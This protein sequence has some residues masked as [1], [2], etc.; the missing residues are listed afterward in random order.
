MDP[1]FRL[2]RIDMKPEMCSLSNPYSDFS[3]CG[4]AQWLLEWSYGGALTY[5][6][7]LCDA[8][9]IEL[10]RLLLTEGHP[11]QQIPAWLT[12]RNGG[13]RCTCGRGDSNPV[14]H[15]DCIIT[16]TREG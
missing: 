12:V 14:H 3:N 7:K 6:L 15:Q 16:Q 11:E 8:H 2:K 10:G 1:G 13:V 5:P 4:Y 9:R